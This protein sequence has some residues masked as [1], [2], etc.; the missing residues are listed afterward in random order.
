[1]EKRAYSNKKEAQRAASK[2]R[3]KGYSVFINRKRI[4]D[5]TYKYGVRTVYILDAKRVRMR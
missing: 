3:R 4:K 1:M 2:L 5:K